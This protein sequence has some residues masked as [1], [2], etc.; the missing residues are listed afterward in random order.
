MKSATFV[1]A[2]VVVYA[3]GK[4]IQTKPG[5]TKT[6]ECGL[7]DGSLILKWMKGTEP[8][9]TINLRTGVPRKGIGEIIQRS[10]VN[11]KNLE[12]FRITAQDAG[13]FTCLV[14]SQMEHYRLVV[15]SAS[16]TPSGPLE[17]G[18]EAVLQCDVT[19][20]PSGAA[21][22]WV[23][24]GGQSGSTPSLHIAAVTK[25]DAGLWECVFSAEG[26]TMKE[27][28]TLEVREPRP[29]T[30]STTTT[31][32][33]TLSAMK[34]TE[35]ILAPCPDYEDCSTA[36]PTPMWTSWWVWAAVGGGALVLLLWVL[37]LVM[38]NRMRRRKRRF[39][40]MRGAVELRPRQYCQCPG[41]PT[42][43]AAHGRT[44][45]SAPP[46][47]APVLSVV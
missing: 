7:G 47:P 45:P 28:V 17:E 4:V 27:T 15:A 39:M 13:E 8:L 24:P 42:A 18:S 12:I 33:T 14:K 25:E 5:Q 40:K 16:V 21:V 44:K 46:F 30:T 34:T 35:A 10:R 36:V 2:L 20:L 6:L 11:D 29:K 19:G 37:I 3:A 9:Y 22:Q 1:L 32:T 43:V 38:F 41:G 26:Q 31:T 23:G